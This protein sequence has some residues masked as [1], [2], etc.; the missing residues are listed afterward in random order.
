MRRLG[1]K[2]VFDL[3]SEAEI[4]RGG[5]DRLPGG[6]V[7]RN[8]PYRNHSFDRA[9]HEGG[10]SRGKSGQLDY[11]M[12]A[13]S[14]YSSLKGAYDAIH[15]IVTA[16]IAGDGPILVHCAAGKD[17]AGWTVAT[18]L[19]AAGVSDADIV[20]DFLRSNSGIGPLRRHM[21][22]VWSKEGSKNSIEP[23]DAM[24]GVSEQYYRHGL[25]T[26]EQVHGSFEG[27]LNAIGISSSV[28]ADLK[29]ALLTD[30][31]NG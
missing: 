7:L 16:L 8:I 21:R 31:P 4:A 24:L 3:R 11:M 9:P 12:R 19:R 14:S 26:V 23:S 1:V 29:G 27:Y 13:Y 5:A 30:R 2:I 15:T 18:V 10:V 28:L 6:V 25:Q 20:A 17:R 22:A